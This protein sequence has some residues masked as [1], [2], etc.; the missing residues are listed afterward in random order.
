MQLVELT[1]EGSPFMQ[2]ESILMKREI[3][4]KTSTRVKKG[5]SL[6]GHLQVKSCPQSPATTRNWEWQLLP[7]SLPAGNQPCR[8]LHLSFS[9]QNREAIR[10]ALL[11]W[12]LHLA[13]LPS[14]SCNSWVQAIL[15]P[16]LPGE[17]RPQ[18]TLLHLSVCLPK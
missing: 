3:E 8:P 1:L 4:T 7:P 18:F 11:F 14:L 5:Q 10:S 9:L 12:N 17:Q 13:R 6:A 2:Y 15:L 16:R